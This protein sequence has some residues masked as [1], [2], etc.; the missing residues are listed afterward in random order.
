MGNSVG[1]LGRG[2]DVRGEG[3]SAT[4][5]PSIHESGVEYSWVDYPHIL[6]PPPIPPV[7]FRLLNE[8]ERPKRAYG[9]RTPPDLDRLADMVAK[10]APGERNHTLNRAAFL[11]Q[12]TV[13]AG[14][15]SESS[16]MSVLA[17]A[18]QDAGL[19]WKEASATIRS[20]LRGAGKKL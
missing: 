7:L 9:F 2:V 4:L 19:T 18:A 17:K 6:R 20:G 15:A 11:A 13:Q 12:K 1:R 14:E 8:V 10:S 5:P 16:V 3:G